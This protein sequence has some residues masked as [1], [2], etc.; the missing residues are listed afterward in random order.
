MDA[1]LK[2]KAKKI[3]IVFFDIDD[4]LRVKHTGYIPAS[5]QQ[6]FKSL[7]DRGILTG[8][9]SGRTPYGLVPEIKALHPDYFVMINGSYVEDAKSKVVYHRPI[10]QNL[11]EAVLNWAQGIGIEYGM[12]GS[13]KGT[14]SARTDRINQVIDLIYEGLEIAPDFYRENDIYQLLTF[15]RD[16]EEVELPEA[17]QAD[18]RSVRWDAISSD[19]VLKDSS[20]ATGVAKIVEKLGLKPEN[21]LVFGDGLNDIEL[22]DYAG[23]S[24]AM[25]HSHPELQKHADYI[26]KKSR[27][28]WHF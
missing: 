28:R 2:Y 21:V 15:E 4:T 1:K 22:F 26:T 18:L 27:R 11:V 13:Q 16:G 10:P 25:G 17:L 14:L 20:K 23:I 6:V 24:I 3:K 12:L 19:I 8:I 5:I 9:A 7:K